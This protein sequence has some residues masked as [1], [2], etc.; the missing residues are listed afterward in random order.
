MTQSKIVFN[1]AKK[2]LKRCCSKDGFLASS[3][4]EDNYKRVF[5][6]DGIIIGLSTLLLNDKE[7]IN[8]FKT[9]LVTL[10]KYQ[11][12]NGAIPSNVDVENKKVSFGRNVG[13]V[14]ATLWFVIGAGQYIKNTKDK[15]FAKKHIRIIR[16]CMS[17]L[18]SWEF[19]DKGFIYVPQGG[20]W[21]DE[22]INEGYV[23]YDQL[24]YYQALREYCF[25]ENFLKKDICNFKETVKFMKNSIK[26]NFWP[27]EKDLM[28]KYVYHN[29]LFNNLLNRKDDEFFISSFTPGSYVNRFD[30]FGNSLAIL[31]GLALNSRSKRL[32]KY[33]EELYKEKKLIPA[34]YPVITKK[35]FEWK[36]LQSNYNFRFKNEPNQFHN[37]G[38]WPL[39]NGF[40][41]AS[42][43][44]HRKKSLAKKMLDELSKI[45]SE[46]DYEFNEFFDGKTLKPKGVK[47]LGF[48][49]AAYIIA[50]KAVKEKKILFD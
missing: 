47:Y 19:N 26:V 46:N 5:S 10:A 21:A 1:E 45:I 48:N 37:G 34:F 14:D 44:K 38:I 8:M 29:S 6:R 18:K 27:E 36:L 39:T 4:N 3:V 13:R 31:F 7:L 43:V 12:K 50:Y 23:L 9:T 35:D 15:E 42:L 32:I 30:C 16:K 17:I 25:C 11:N 2:I 20:D 28:S 49:A 41:I 24:L 40:L 22:Y 33:I